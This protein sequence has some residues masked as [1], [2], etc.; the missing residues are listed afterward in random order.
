MSTKKSAHN[1]LVENMSP[2]RIVPV[3]G[4]LE[5]RIKAA[6]K[7]SLAMK[8]ISPCC[9]YIWNHCTLKGG[10]KTQRFSRTQ[11]LYASEEASLLRDL[12]RIWLKRSLG[13]GGSCTN[14]ARMAPYESAE[15]LVK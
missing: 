13:E 2:R 15:K 1:P 7:A 6:F 8:G 4:S 9:W 12:R 11:S 3:Q 14:V 5:W 10:V